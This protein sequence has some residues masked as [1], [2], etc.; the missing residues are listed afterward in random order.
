MAKPMNSG[1]SGDKWDLMVYINF[2]IYE[3]Y[4]TDGG[5]AK[6]WK[7]LL[8]IVEKFAGRTKD[9]TQRKVFFVA[10]MPHSL[11]KN[12][13]FVKDEKYTKRTN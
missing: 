2:G 4:F 13:T 5:P 9:E 7:H 3:E 10:N 1:D 12:S 8:A 6:I 11:L